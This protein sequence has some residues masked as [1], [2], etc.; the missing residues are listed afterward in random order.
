MGK[1]VAE[2]RKRWPEM[3]EEYRE[4]C[5]RGEFVPDDAFM[6]VASDRVDFKFEYLPPASG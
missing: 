2:L 4:R 5:R 1:G 3:F 6:W